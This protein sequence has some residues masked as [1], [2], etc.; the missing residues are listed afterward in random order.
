MNDLSNA[1]SKFHCQIKRIQLIYPEQ[2][3]PKNQSTEL[4]SYVDYSTFIALA[5]EIN[6]TENSVVLIEHEFKIFGGPGGDIIMY[7]LQ[8]INVPSIATLH[9][10]NKNLDKDRLR[11]FSF[12][13]KKLDYSIVFCSSAADILSTQYQVDKSKIHITRH[14][15]RLNSLI[16]NQK[17]LLR[18]KYPDDF[19]IMTPGFIRPTKGYDIVLKALAY[20]N[21]SVKFKYLIIGEKHPRDRNASEYYDSLMLMVDRLK[22]EDRVVFFNE[23]LNDNKYMQVLSEANLGILAY[24]RFEQSSSGVL[25]QFRALNIPVIATGFLQAQEMSGNDSGVKIFNGT[26]E[27]LRY[28][29]DKFISVDGYPSHIH[30]SDQNNIFS[31]DVIAKDYYAIIRNLLSMN[32]MHE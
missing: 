12:L 32:A 26:P 6:L 22:L 19:L 7:F 5:K 2:S 13:C 23:Y 21:P 18:N 17:P 1:L 3:I 11:V 29:I 15:V 27:S 31:W 25:S 20:L 9:T 30:K 8:N 16:S 10:V 24:Q 28:S 4:I 14:G